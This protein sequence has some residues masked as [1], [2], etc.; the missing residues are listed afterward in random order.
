MVGDTSLRTAITTSRFAILRAGWP[1]HEGGGSTQMHAITASSDTHLASVYDP[2][3]S[4][5]CLEQRAV[6]YVVLCYSGHLDDTGSVGTSSLPPFELTRRARC[7][8]RRTWSH[9]EVLSRQYCSTANH[10]DEG[11]AIDCSDSR[12]HTPCTKRKAVVELQRDAFH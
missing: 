10:V 11:I 5:P 3:R 8:V 12:L 9:S 4:L 1:M 6:L 7:S 2:P